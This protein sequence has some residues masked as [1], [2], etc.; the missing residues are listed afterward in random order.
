MFESRAFKPEEDVEDWEYLPAENDE[1]ITTP[2]T[3]FVF[4]IDN[5]PLGVGTVIGRLSDKEDIHPVIE[6]DDPKAPTGKVHLLGSECWWGVV[7]TAVNSITPEG[8]Q[9]VQ[10]AYEYVQRLDEEYQAS[11]N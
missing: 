1:S 2:F 6:I 3:A 5:D 7:D 11:L 9:R 8:M 10:S 4:T